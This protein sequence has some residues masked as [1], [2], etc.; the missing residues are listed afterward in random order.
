MIYGFWMNF[1]FN[2]KYMYQLR[3]NLLAYYDEKSVIKLKGRLKNA[4]LDSNTKHP[5]L[6][7]KRNNF[8]ELI[9]PDAHL[10]VKV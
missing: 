5:I 1:N 2:Q 4:Q 6:L 8:T 3:F 7:S 10:R 9:I